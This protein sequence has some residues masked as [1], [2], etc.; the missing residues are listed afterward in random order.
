[1]T[2]TAALASLLFEAE[3]KGIGRDVKEGLSM[4]EARTLGTR[5]TTVAVALA[6]RITHSRRLAIITAAPSTN[7]G[8]NFSLVIL[9]SY[10]SSD[11]AGSFII[12]ASQRTPAEQA[13]LRRVISPL[14]QPK[15]CC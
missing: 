4:T 5:T 15:G 14:Q 7:N 11:R 12:R 6:H 8:D 10:K 2:F 1:M 13:G 9:H 3:N